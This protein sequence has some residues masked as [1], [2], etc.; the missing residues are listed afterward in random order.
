[1]GEEHRKVRADSEGRNWRER[2][3]IVRVS[4]C[5]AISSCGPKPDSDEPADF[6]RSGATNSLGAAGSTFIN[7]IMTAW[8][9]DYQELHPKIQIN[10]R[11]MGSGGG[12]DELKQ[13]MLEFAASDAPL[14]DA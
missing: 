4:V 14:R 2:L 13:G 12:I 3:P 1:L 11:P 6:A 10:Y 8:I 5:V 7:P 9:S